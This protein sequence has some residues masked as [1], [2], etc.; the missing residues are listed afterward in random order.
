MGVLAA[1]RGVRPPRAL[2][3]PFPHGYTLGS[4]ADPA[5]QHA[6]LEA[7]LRLLERPDREPP[8]LEDYSPPEAP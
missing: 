5:A 4:P 7:A 8:V 2:W 1:C 6:V 3:V